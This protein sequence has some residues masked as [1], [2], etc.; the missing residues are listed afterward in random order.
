[1]QWTERLSVGANGRPMSLLGPK[2]TY[3]QQSSAIIAFVFND[4]QLNDRFQEKP[5]VRTRPNS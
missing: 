1:M 4:S 5:P 3:T 2:L